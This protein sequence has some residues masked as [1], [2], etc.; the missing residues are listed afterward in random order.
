M[1]KK[2]KNEPKFCFIIS[3]IGSVNSDERIDAIRK[4]RHFFKPIL[5]ELKYESKRADEDGVPG[6][7]STQIIKRLIDSSLVIADISFENTN[8]FY[9]LAVRHAIKKPVIIIK[10]P[11]QRMPFDITDIRA[12]DVDMTDPDIWQSAMGDLRK[13]IQEAEN[14]PEKASESI[15]SNFTRSFNLETKENKESD[16]LRTVK[17]IKAQVNRMGTDVDSLKNKTSGVIEGDPGFY[18]FEPSTAVSGIGLDNLV[19]AN[20]VGTNII[21]GTYSLRCKKCKTD[22]IASLYPPYDLVDNKIKNTEQCIHCGKKSNYSSKDYV[23]TNI[24]F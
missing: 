10:K 23:K 4:S 7:I 19:P 14:D 12:I 24:M 16:I 21:G 18:S 17:D 15:L 3:H 8:V 9:E 22:F 20:T 5:K 13:Y 2:E 1:V 11:K 6:F